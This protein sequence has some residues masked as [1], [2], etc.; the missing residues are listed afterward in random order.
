[1]VH[2][3]DDLFSVPYMSGVGLHY[4]HYCLSII[5]SSARG[6]YSNSIDTY[7]VMLPSGEVEGYVTKSEVNRYFLEAQLLL[8]EA[9]SQYPE[10]YI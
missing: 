5:L 9:Q 1:M 7:E 4:K 10:F 8:V 2:F 3:L 6:I